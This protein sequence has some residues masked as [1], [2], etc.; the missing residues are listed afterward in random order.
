[1]A[2]SILLILDNEAPIAADAIGDLFRSF[3]RDYRNLTRGGMLVVVRLEQGSTFIEWTDHFVA[4]AGH[5][6]QI[7]VDTIKA[8]KNLEKFAKTLKSLF[9]KKKPEQL[10]LRMARRTKKKPLER[11]AESLAKI[12]VRHNCHARLKWTTAEGEMLEF[13]VSPARASEYQE[14][15]RL[16]RAAS[17]EASQLEIPEIDLQRIDENVP[18]L[19][20]FTLKLFDA[21]EGGLSA[22][23]IGR[24][25]ETLVRLLDSSRR[26]EQF[27]SAF[28]AN[29]LHEVASA[30]R[31]KAD[32]SSGKHEPN[33]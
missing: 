15:V 32:R 17:Q 4:H 5:Y 7:A 9:E 8:V 23:E 1:M 29:G 19:R 20:E 13:E 21:H 2:E 12:A 27:A 31:Q 25:A 10:V 16:E 24:V 28:E 14:E 18:L 22:I 33:A 11:S 26:V 6:A 30:L 3:A